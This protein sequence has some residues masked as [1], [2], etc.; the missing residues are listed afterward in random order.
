VAR[1]DVVR[2]IIR[3]IKEMYQHGDLF[4]YLHGQ[5]QRLLELGLLPLVQIFKALL[6]ALRGPEDEHARRAEIH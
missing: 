1:L 4:A 2:K 5:E 6:G 3:N